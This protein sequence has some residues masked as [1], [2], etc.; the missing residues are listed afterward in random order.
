VD[1]T[2]TLTEAGIKA[3]QEKGL[4]TFFKLQAKMST[5]NMMLFDASGKI[6]KYESPEHIIKDFF[7]L[8]LDHYAK[9]RISLLA[10]AQDQLQRISNKVPRRS[11]LSLRHELR[12]LPSETQRQSL[13]H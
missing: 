8:R 13:I 7:E 12:A 10:R 1:F 2:V 5:S 11:N 4:V 9:R 6:V 3:V